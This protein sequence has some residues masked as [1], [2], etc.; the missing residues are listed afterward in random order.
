MPLGVIAAGLLLVVGLL[1]AKVGDLDGQLGTLTHQTTVASV[2]LNPAHKTVE[3]TSSAHP[4][5]RATVIF[6][7]DGDGYLVN[8]T[9]PSLSRSQTFQLWALSSGKVVSLGVLGSHPSGAPLRIEPTMTV[10][11]ITAEPLGGTPVPTTPVLVR[12]NLPVT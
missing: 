6:L 8:P 12:G 5:W 1:A 3:L 10:L 4:V 9:M 7:Q 2:L 11:M